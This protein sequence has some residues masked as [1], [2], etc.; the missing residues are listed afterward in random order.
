MKGRK[1]PAS[2]HASQP[3]R[4]RKRRDGGGQEGGAKEFSSPS[5]SL[6]LSSLVPRCPYKCPFFP[7]FFPLMSPGAA[8]SFSLSYGSGWW[9]GSLKTFGKGGGREGDRLNI[10]CWSKTETGERNH[11]CR[12]NGLTD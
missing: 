10:C 8:A 3:A 2:N 5:Y 4:G 11:P 6:P 9:C 7:S 12:P 1:T